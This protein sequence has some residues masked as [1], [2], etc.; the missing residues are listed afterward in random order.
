MKNGYKARNLA[1]APHCRAPEG[2]GEGEGGRGREREGE[3]G[4]GREG[5][6]GRRSQPQTPL[7]SPPTS[8]TTL[9]S[10]YPNPS[11]S[12]TNPYTLLTLR[13]LV[14]YAGE[15]YGVA[16]SRSA[17]SSFTAF[18]LNKPTSS[19]TPTFF[20][21]L[22]PHPRGSRNS[23]VS[24]DDGQSFKSF[25]SFKR[26]SSVSAVVREPEKE[27]LNRLHARLISVVTL[28]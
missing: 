21:L 19:T 26:S 5:G 28:D 18:A 3:R 4:R 9:S 8:S 23:S 16:R 10:S 27:N 17:S 24:S 1:A 14:S 13:D 12:S 22:L 20:L 25:K 7:P 15:W 11:Y 6:R 2:E